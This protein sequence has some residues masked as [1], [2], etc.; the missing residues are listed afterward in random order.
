MNLRLNLSNSLATLVGQLACRAPF[1]DDSFAVA[2]RSAN[3]TTG[4]T[5]SLPNVLALPLA[6]ASSGPFAAP[7]K[8]GWFLV[9]MVGSR[10]EPL[11]NFS[12]AGR[13]LALQGA[14]FENS[15]DRFGHIQP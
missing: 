12:W 11:N 5:Q 8:G 4:A 13:M 2:D 10:F 9:P 1:L 6:E 7:D 3:T 14:S 15:L